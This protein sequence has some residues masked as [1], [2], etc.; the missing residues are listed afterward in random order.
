M[1]WSR[2]ELGR[3]MGPRSTGPSCMNGFGLNTRPSTLLTCGYKSGVCVS[4][5]MYVCVYIY[6]CI[7]CL[8]LM[9]GVNKV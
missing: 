2:G 3:R 5:D 9:Y 1:L 8:S 4:F 7:M 6:I